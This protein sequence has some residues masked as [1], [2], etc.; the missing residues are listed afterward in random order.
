MENIVVKSFDVYRDGGS[1]GGKVEINGNTLSIMLK[2]AIPIYI[3]RYKRA[4]RYD[5]LYVSN[6][7]ITDVLN[8]DKIP[9]KSEEMLIWLN[10]LQSANIDQLDSE[11][12]KNFG[13][14]IEIIKEKIYNIER[15][16]DKKSIVNDWFADILA[17]NSQVECERHDEN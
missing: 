3:E 14:F 15:V 5:Y 4:E 8:G 9:V 7:D 11:S 1:Y 2:I 6:S 13:I 17:Y 16:L 12:Q 10:I